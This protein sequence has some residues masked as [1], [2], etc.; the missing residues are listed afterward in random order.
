[1]RFE[2]VEECNPRVGERQVSERDES[3]A[4]ISERSFARVGC[5]A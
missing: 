5:A 3:P 2:V 1:M 4:P